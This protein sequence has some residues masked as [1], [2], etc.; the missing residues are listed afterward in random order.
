MVPLNISR[1]GEAGV[2]KPRPFTRRSVEARLNRLRGFFTHTVTIV[3]DP[4]CHK[5]R[6]EWKSTVVMHIRLVPASASIISCGAVSIATRFSISWKPMW[7]NCLVRLPTTSATRF[8]RW[9]LRTKTTTYICT[10]LCKLT[11]STVQWI[12][13]G[14]SSRTRVSSCWRGI[15]RFGSRISGVADSGRSDTP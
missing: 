12:L 14:S 15:P 3:P 9:R 4:D 10:C 2:V 13:L 7:K 6:Y 11:Q 1:E 5:C 8:W